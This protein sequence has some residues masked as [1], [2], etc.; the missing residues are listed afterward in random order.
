MEFFG[1]NLLVEGIEEWSQIAPRYN[2]RTFHP[3]MLEIE[4][5]RMFGAVEMTAVILGV[6]F[7]IRWTYT[8]TEAMRRTCGDMDKIKAALSEDGE[9][10]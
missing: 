5:D 7:R 8:E 4:D 10:K 6:G 9:Q 2:W 3:V 1:G